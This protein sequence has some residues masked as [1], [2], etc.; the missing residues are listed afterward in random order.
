MK[1][2]VLP[3]VL[4]LAC[5]SAHAQRTSEEQTVIRVAREVTPAVV[6]V[7]RS[8]GSGSGVIIRS[9]GVVTN[10]HVVGRAQRVTVRLA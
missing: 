5:V 1:R 8:G 4:L 2:I 6:S 3:G 7:M 10:A 9:D